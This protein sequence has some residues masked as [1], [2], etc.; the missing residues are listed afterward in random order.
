VYHEH[1]LG[2]MKQAKYETFVKLVNL[3]R[4][5]SVQFSIPSSDALKEMKGEKKDV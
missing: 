4:S 2:K 1:L 5:C 3:I